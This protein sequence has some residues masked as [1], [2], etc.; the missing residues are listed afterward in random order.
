MPRADP[1]GNRGNRSTR[2]KACA[3]DVGTDQDIGGDCALRNDRVAA[4]CSTHLEGS[5]ELRPLIGCSGLD[6]DQAQSGGM[7][8]ADGHALGSERQVGPC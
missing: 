6:A 5:S 4:G 3:Q 7:H 1:A 8:A 2:R